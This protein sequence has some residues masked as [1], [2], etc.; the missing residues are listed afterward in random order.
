MHAPA[1]GQ[2]LAKF[3]GD[4]VAS[5]LDVSALRPSRFSESALTTP[6]SFSEMRDPFSRRFAR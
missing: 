6:R 3:I 5:S 2:L 4:G 1:F